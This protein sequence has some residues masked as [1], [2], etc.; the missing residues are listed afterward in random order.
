MC[1]YNIRINNRRNYNINEYIYL[2]TNICS[3]LST[4]KRLIIY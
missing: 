4:F 2:L 1:V 3:Y